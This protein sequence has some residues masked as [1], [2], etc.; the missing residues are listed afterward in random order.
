[1]A[2]KSMASDRETRGLFHL[3]LSYVQSSPTS[4]KVRPVRIQEDS[5]GWSEILLERFAHLRK[6]A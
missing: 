4:R 2:E 6:V 3:L 1:M 5:L